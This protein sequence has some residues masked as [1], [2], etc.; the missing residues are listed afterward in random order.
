MNKTVN[1]TWPTF[2]CNLADFKSFFVLD[3]A[4]RTRGHSLKISK[5][6]SSRDIQKH[7]LSNKVVNRW[8]SL[9]EH[10]V[11][12]SS[13]NVFKNGLQKLRS[14]KMGFFMDHYW[15]PPTVEVGLPAPD[16][17]T[18]TAPGAT[19]PGKLPGTLTKKVIQLQK[20]PSNLQTSVIDARVELYDYRA[21]NNLLQKVARRLFATLTHDF[22]SKH[23][24]KI[25]QA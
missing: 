17:N 9:P 23:R 19:A 18:G 22:S 2:Y 13:I 14:T 11:Q 8:N 4:G 12:A 25:L 6:S 20:L 5:Q 15:C 16:Q 3:T 1:I 7:F 24:R 21:A 10:I